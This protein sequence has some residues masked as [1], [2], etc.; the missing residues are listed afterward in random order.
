MMYGTHADITEMREQQ[1]EAHR[2]SAQLQAILDSATGV[3][4]IAT[5]PDGLITLFN[6]GAQRLLDLCDKHQ[7]R[8]EWVRGHNGNPENECCD[9]L[10]A[11][12][13]RETNLPS[14]SNYVRS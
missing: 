5:N 2:T 12:A 14:D 10:A 4:V 13:A 3:S 11:A 7:V 6:R 8:F 9:R 1:D